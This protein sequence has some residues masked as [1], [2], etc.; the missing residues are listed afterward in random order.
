MK[1][2]AVSDLLVLALEELFKKEKTLR[3]SAQGLEREGNMFYSLNYTMQ[4]DTAGGSLG[5]QAPAAI[6]QNRTSEREV[7]PSC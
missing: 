1:R 2:L 3:S 7:R 5:R 4:N 6:T